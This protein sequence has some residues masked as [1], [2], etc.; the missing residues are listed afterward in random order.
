MLRGIKGTYIYVCDPDL[1]KYF[2]SFIPK[3]I[4]EEKTHEIKFKT[5]EIVPYENALPFFDLKI[6]AGS[7]SDIQQVDEVQWVELPKD[8]K[9]NK[10]LFICQVVGESMNKIIPNGAFCLFK[11]YT[12]G[13]RNGHIVLVECN[14][15]HD[16]DFGSSYT[17]KEYA[18]K[19]YE[20]ENGWK[21]QSI[22]LKPISYDSGYENIVLEGDQLSSFKVI[23]TFQTV[24]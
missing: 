17:I 21:H 19:K 18:S 23:G 8:I 5:D 3:F 10:D 4:S 14:E 22:I 12:G 24:L 20:D 11:K 16:S 9:P 15:I 6:A 2:E 7:F 1:K 13:S